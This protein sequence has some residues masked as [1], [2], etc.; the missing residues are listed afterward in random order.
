MAKEGSESSGAE[1][2]PKEIFDERRREVKVART[3]VTEASTRVRATIEKEPTPKTCA[4]IRAARDQL[5]GLGKRLAKATRKLLGSREGDPTRFE[6]WRDAFDLHVDSTDQHRLQKFHLLLK[7]INEKVTKCIASL[8]VSESNYESAR[9]TIY[10]LYGDICMAEDQHVD[11]LMEACNRR[12]IH[13]SR[14]FV[15]FV[16]DVT[17]SVQS[18]VALGNTLEGMSAFPVRI[19][20]KAL[21]YDRKRRFDDAYA[22]TLGG[23]DRECRLKALLDFLYAEQKQVGRLTL[24]YRSASERHA[25]HTE[26]RDKFQK[27]SGYKPFHGRFGHPKFNPAGAPG[28]IANQHA[29]AGVTAPHRGDNNSCIFCA[30]NHRSTM[31]QKQMS[32]S[33]R[34]KFVSARN[35]CYKC[36]DGGHLVGNCKA[37]GCQK[38]K[39]SHHMLLCP[40]PG[41]IKTTAVVSANDEDAA[42][43]NS[44]KIVNVSGTRLPTGYVEILSDDR[45]TV[46]RI[47][48][49]TGSQ[50]TLITNKFADKLNAKQMGSETFYLHSAGQADPK[51]CV[52]R[53][54]EVTMKSRFS[55]AHMVIYATALPNVVEGRLPE[56]DFGGELAPI[57]DKNE[58]QWNTDLD[59]LVGVD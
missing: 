42:S 17:Q 38:C 5:S 26:R 49:E 24:V 10:D 19:I 16:T 7:T 57:A 18:L 40:K 51:K 8:E 13:S 20:L 35:V 2:S 23:S 36:L 34:R 1:Q 54:V 48:F 11:S 39:M 31:C 50:K 43:V 46:G 59:I 45:K 14:S 21:P 30:G 3:L 33:E 47:V 25:H 52:G 9:D 41:D 4:E 27:P 29:F 56:A 37:K 22:T 15:D 32:V 12:D 53:I 28:T 58:G 44:I 55:D 6:R